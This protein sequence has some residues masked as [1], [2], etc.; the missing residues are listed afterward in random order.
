MLGDDVGIDRVIGSTRQAGQRPVIPSGVE[1][2]EALLVE[3]TERFEPG[4]LA[5]QAVTPIFLFSSAFL[6]F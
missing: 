3:A 1:A 4:H 6:A 5:Y 2:V